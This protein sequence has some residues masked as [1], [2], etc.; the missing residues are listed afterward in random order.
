MRRPLAIFDLII[1][2]I[3]FV[4]A[5]TLPLLIEIGTNTQEL[6]IV[7]LAVVLLQGVSFWAIQRNTRHTIE[8]V[9]RM[10]QDRV[11]NQLQIIV[12][13]LPPGTNKDDLAAVLSAVQAISDSLQLLSPDSLRA[14]VTRYPSEGAPR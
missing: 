3:G 6:A 8:L 10:L 2:G 4:I 1:A 12:S 14:W 5:L 7:A 9:R 13:A 11:R